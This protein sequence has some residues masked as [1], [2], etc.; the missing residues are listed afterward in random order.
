VSSS[1]DEQARGVELGDH[2]GQ[3]CLDQLMFTQQTPELF[4]VR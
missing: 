1:I 2:V 4:A 3:F